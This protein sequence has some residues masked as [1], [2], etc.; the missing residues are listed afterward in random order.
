[1]WAARTTCARPSVAAA[2]AASTSARG[3]R[4]SGGGG[5]GRGGSGRSPPSAGRG[6]GA[7]TG[8]PGPGSKPAA[9]PGPPAPPSRPA[10]ASAPPPK[11][12]AP[13][14]TTRPPSAATTADPTKEAHKLFDEVILRVRAGAGGRGEVS[15]KGG[16]RTVKNFKYAPGGRKGG[17]EVFLAASP[18]ADGAP[19]GDVVV[20]ADPALGSLLHLHGGPAER[21]APDGQA[22]NPARGSAGPRPTGSIGSAAARAP[23]RPPALILRVPPGTVVRRGPGGPV[24]GEVVA[25]GQRLVVARGGAG[26]PGVVGNAAG[27]LGGGGASSS[28]SSSRRRR[29]GSRYVFDEDDDA[30][31]VPDDA[32]GPLDPAGAP[33]E[34]VALHLLLR[35][36]A[37]VGL[38]G[39]PNA[40]KSSLLAAL[41]A[42]R[43]EVGAHPFTTL[44]PNLGVLSAAVAAGG[45]EKG[46]GGGSLLD[47][48]E[49]TRRELG[50]TGSP[51]PVLAD[52]PGLIPGAHAGRGL[53][54]AFL[55]HARRAAALLHVLDGT[56]ADPGGDYRGIR[57]ELALYNPAYA[58]RP[59][60]VAFNKADML[61]GE[62]GVAGAVEAFRA[63]LEEGEEEGEAP[64]TA[65]RTRPPLAIIPTSAVAGTGLAALA[66]ALEEA[67][68]VAKVWE[69]EEADRGAVGWD[70]K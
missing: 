15:K 52:L 25:P 8:K 26:G 19:G 70:V 35:V 2:A 64:T 18:P 12:K 17:R 1:M 45:R 16:G 54:R 57:R 62:E 30:G 37:D 61:G 67:L 33:G 68:R 50:L 28:A 32:G 13:T 58:A 10:S 41:T 14:T 4:G 23:P 66:A 11:K 36:V 69:A 43:P 51:P 59:H 63:A 29:G 49:V 7:R 48:E 20:M 40:G 56:G 38:V 39:A 65:R 5:G 21:A 3:G 44:M 27:S 53:G 47:Q 42:A 9:R 46:E 22:G 60:V 31:L 55:R 34:A 24:I 6:A